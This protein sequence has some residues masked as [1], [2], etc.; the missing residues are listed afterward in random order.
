MP[1]LR[2]LTGCVRVFHDHVSC[3]SCFAPTCGFQNRFASRG[4]ERAIP[5]S[6]QETPKT[7]L[8]YLHASASYQQQLVKHTRQKYILQEPQKAE[9]NKDWKGSKAPTLPRQTKKPGSVETAIVSCF[10]RDT[11]RH[12]FHDRRGPYRRESRCQ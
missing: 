4:T 7:S 3:F 6:M 8:P 1:H 2:V 12:V 9:A 11:T 5:Y 10:E